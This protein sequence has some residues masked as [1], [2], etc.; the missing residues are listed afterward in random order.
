M[1]EEPPQDLRDTTCSER[2]DAAESMDQATVTDRTDQLALDVAHVIQAAVL[3]GFDLDVQRDAAMRRRQGAHDD[4]G[5]VL[6]EPVGRTDDERWTATSWLVREGL[7]EIDEPEI[8]NRC[9][10]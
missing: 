6:A 3:D 9:H 5:D 4:E 10:R 1:V 7:A 8:V 2:V